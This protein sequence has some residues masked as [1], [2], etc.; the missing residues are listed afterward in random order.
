MF[1]RVPTNLEE[2]EIQFKDRYKDNVHIDMVV[3]CMM[4][5]LRCRIAEGETFIKAYQHTL[6]TY[7]DIA[8]KKQKA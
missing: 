3:K 1:N 4:G 7:L 2:A 5:I 6:E 8:D